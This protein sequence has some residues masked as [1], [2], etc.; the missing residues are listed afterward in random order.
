[1]TRR[2]DPSIF[3]ALIGL[4][5]FIAA[6]AND[7]VST[8]SQTMPAIPRALSVPSG[9]RLAQKV[10]ASGVQTYVCTPKADQSGFE[11][12]FKAP[13]ATLEDE[14]GALIGTHYAGPTWEA[15]D[16]SKIVGE[17]KAR[18]DSSDPDA[19]PWLPLAARSVGPSGAF[20]KTT[21]VQRLETVAGKA[22]KGGC[23]GN[24]SNQEVRVAYNAVYYFYEAVR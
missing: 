13:E 23:S 20:A 14:S 24:A 16:G 12:T 19:I 7:E 21:F 11:W 4:S 18:L 6:R 10:F 17:V 9:H 1:M 5:G 22:P 15:R 8:S 3:A 2:I